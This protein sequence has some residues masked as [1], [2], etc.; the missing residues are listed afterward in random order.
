MSITTPVYVLPNEVKRK[1][2][3]DCYNALIGRGKSHDEA[4]YEV[5]HCIVVSRLCD[6]ENLVDVFKYNL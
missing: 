6:L 2:L 1:V 3:L 4:K 5:S